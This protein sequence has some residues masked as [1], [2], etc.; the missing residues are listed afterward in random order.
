[1]EKGT[2]LSYSEGAKLPAEA[3]EWALAASERLRDRLKSGSLGR[4]VIPPKGVRKVLLHSCCAPCSG[5]MV[6]E[7]CASEVLDEVVVFF[8]NPNIHPRKEYEIRKVRLFSSATGPEVWQF[9]CLVGDLN[10]S[11]AHILTS[12]LTIITFSYAGGEQEILFQDRCGV[13]R[14]RL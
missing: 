12:Y 2:G 14:L 7:M 11:F 4:R 5:A 13:C 10:N 9:H 6:E 8:Y 3:P 1:M